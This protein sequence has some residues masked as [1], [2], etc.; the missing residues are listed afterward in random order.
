MTSA[1]PH[2]FWRVITYAIIPMSG[3]SIKVRYVL[4]L[5]QKNFSHNN[6]GESS[7]LSITVFFIKTYARIALKSE[8]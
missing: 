3:M 2:R 6:D 8:R 5:L 1:P 4:Q 7:P